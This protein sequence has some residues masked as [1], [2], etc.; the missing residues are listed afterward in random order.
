MSISLSCIVDIKTML[1][2]GIIRLWFKNNYFFKSK[3]SIWPNSILIIH[4]CIEHFKQKKLI[5]YIYI[6]ILLDK[7]RYTTDHHIMS[8]N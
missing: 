1:N 3:N 7:Y 5:P 6:Y 8:F 4:I 2:N